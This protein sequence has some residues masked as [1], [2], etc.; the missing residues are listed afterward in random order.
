MEFFV[1]R[2]WFLWKNLIKMT[3]VVLPN[4]SAETLSFWYSAISTFPLRESVLGKCSQRFTEAQPLHEII[5]GK[6][7]AQT[8][9]FVVFTWVAVSQNSPVTATA[10]LRSLKAFLQWAKC[11]YH[12]RYPTPLVSSTQRTSALVHPIVRCLYWSLLY[13][14]QSL[15]KIRNKQLMCINLLQKRTFANMYCAIFF[16]VFV[17]GYCNL[18]AF[19]L[20]N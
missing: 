12:Q 17:I 7:L 9:Q 18:H 19:L 10:H 1:K 11:S 2:Q 13:F 14:N 3:F 6:V 16:Y 8:W 20:K 5:Q 15:N 4:P